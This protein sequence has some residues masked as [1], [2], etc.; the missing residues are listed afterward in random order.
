MALISLRGV[1]IQYGGPAVLDNV[2]FSIEPG[3]RACI[4]GRN[5]EGKST[6][7]KIIA[8]LIKPDSGEIIRQPGLRVAYLTQDVPEDIEGTVSDIVEKG[9]GAEA[10]HTHHPGSN[11][12]LSQLELDGDV[13][14][15]TLSGGMRRRVL[16]ARALVS[17][18]NLLLLDEPTNHLDIESIEWLE[19]FLRKSRCACLFV[20][21][22]RSFL[23]RVAIKVLDLDRGQLAGWDCDYATFV[24]RKQDLLNDEAVF[25][26][27]KTKKLAQEEAWIRRGV[28]ARTCRNEGRVVA[29]L[30]LRE[31]FKQRRTQSGVSRLQLDS[32]EASGE[33]VLK[34]NEASFAYPGGKPIIRDFTAKVL[35]GERIGIIGPN[36]SGKTTLLN[37]LCC[38]LAPTQGTITPGA[39]VEL[40]FFD[41]LRTALDLE[42]SVL[43]NLADDKDEV[44]VGGVRKHVYGYLQDFLFTPDR[45]RTPVKALSGGERARL[46]LAKLF[47]QPGN[48]LV[49]D[50]PTNDLDIETLELLEEQLLSYT[51]TLL[52]VSHD[53]TFLDNVVTSTFVLEGD[54]KVGLYPGGYADW[55]QQR[56]KAETEVPKKTDA[57]ANRIT[58]QQRKTARLSHKELRERQELPAL[59]EKLESE[60]A[61]LHATLCDV[62]LYQKSPATAEAAKVR[63]PKAEKELENAFA[64]WADIEERAAKLNP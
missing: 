61:A 50:E 42:A 21:H 54:G 35:R 56:P 22:D 48:L 13:P 2:S 16:L 59:I 31:E 39:R 7:L 30:K 37:L 36:G 45:A 14:F 32:S 4:T 23:K 15:N 26:E 51:G 64:R 57:V 25:W 40:A 24:Q 18:P 11:L 10:D 47:L 9:I 6:L 52:L 58:S 62:A 5:G 46:L 19:S 41:Q 60:I 1:N 38:R 3:D 17:D 8:G 34:I 20:T 29:L 44:V 49:M 63:L 27:R 55:L 28:K 43:H 53:R 12:Y 33:Q